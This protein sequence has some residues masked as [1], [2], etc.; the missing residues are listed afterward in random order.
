MSKGEFCIMKCPYAGWKLSLTSNGQVLCEV[1]NKAKRLGEY[2]SHP[3]K[4][5]EKITTKD[6]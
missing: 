4:K 1:D 5:L 2:C 6:C 3:E